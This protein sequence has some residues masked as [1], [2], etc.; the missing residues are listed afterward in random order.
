MRKITATEA[1]K[2]IGAYFDLARR[3][4][5]IVTQHRRDSVVMI[6]AE[7]YERFR[8]LDDR[9]ACDPAD[10]PE[11]MIQEL[12]ASI[13]RDKANGITATNYPVEKF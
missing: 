4:P 9:V 13:E 7:D 8:R 3:E 6:S 12:E 1:G 10:L 5:V 2:N 11:D